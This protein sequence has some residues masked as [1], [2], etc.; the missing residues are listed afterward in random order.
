[1]L[2]GQKH[3]HFIPFSDKINDLIFL[4]SQKSQF[5]AV[6]DFFWGT[7]PKLLI[8]P[9]NQLSFLRPSGSN[10]MHNIQKSN[11]QILREKW[12]GR[13]EFKLRCRTK[14]ESNWL[15]FHFELSY[16]DCTPYINQKH[17]WQILPSF[18]HGWACLTTSNKKCRSFF[19]LVT[20]SKKKLSIDW[21]WS[22]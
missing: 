5:W 14:Q 18:G 15:N 10:F 4:K 17:L 20:I 9:N 6:F 2:K 12:T 21:Y 1:M 13:P 7:F 19:S 22:F 3:F 11:E 16:P 8:F